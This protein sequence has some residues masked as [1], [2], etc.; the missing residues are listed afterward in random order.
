M[1]I[2]TVLGTR[3]EIIRLSEVIPALDKVSQHT[4][5]YT[6]QNFDASLSTQF[7]EGFSLRAPDLQW[8]IAANHMAQQMPLLWENM[9]RTLER[10]K[11]DR[12]L[13]LGDTNSALTALVAA[14]SGI[15][16]YHMEAG[17]RCYDDT[18]PEEINRRVIDHVSHILMPYTYRSMEN[19]VR[20]GIERHRIV[21]TGNPIYEVLEKNALGIRSSPILGRLGVASHEYFLVT[22]HRSEN[23]DNPERLRGIYDALVSMLDTFGMPMIISLHPRT[24]DRLEREG[25]GLQHPSMKVL[26]PLG[27]HDFIRLEQDAALVLTDSGTVQEECAIFGVPS[28]TL[29]TVTERPETIE[30]GSN[31]LAGTCSQSILDAATLVMGQADFH[32]T[33]PREYLLSNVSDIVTRVLLGESLWRR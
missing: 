21:V 13:L 11:P 24:R 18:V 33:P 31:V 9:S 6:G 30:C 1:K 27:F 2:L 15:P 10:V 12:V 5:V 28:I 8:E 16:V 17:N 3:P 22:V 14:R 19:L 29:R 4:V 23:V 7:F 32:W 20:E 26:D 25:L